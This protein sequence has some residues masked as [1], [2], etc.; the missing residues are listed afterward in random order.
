MTEK[1]KIELI[2]YAVKASENSYSPYSAFKVGASVLTAGGHIY[3]GCNIENAS[4][5]P[6]V[7]AERVAVFK[8]VSE[9]CRDFKAIAVVCESKEKYCSPCGVCRQVMSEFFDDSTLI[10][11]SNPKMEYKEFYLND[12]LPYRFNKDSLD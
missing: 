5:T 3:S 4:Y 8:A 9:G 11:L 10:L 6:T 2:E 12:L 1:E 7:C